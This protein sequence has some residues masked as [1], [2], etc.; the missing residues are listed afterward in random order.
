MEAVFHILGDPLTVCGNLCNSN[1]DVDAWHNTLN[2]TRPSESRHFQLSSPNADDTG[3]FS[4]W[5]YRRC[6]MK[7]NI[8]R[9]IITNAAISVATANA[10]VIVNLDRL[11]ESRRSGC[12]ASCFPDLT[13]DE[14]SVAR[15][16]R[17]EER[18]SGGT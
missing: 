6:L 2:E 5:E 17:A 9:V 12:S 16:V 14:A 10:K 13:V 7:N 18:G 4:L 15:F 3:D 8:G 11:E 1:S